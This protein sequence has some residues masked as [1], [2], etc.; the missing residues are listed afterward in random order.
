MTE[1]RTA[2]AAASGILGDRVA[3]LVLAICHETGNWVSAIRMNA[4][5][6]DHEQA[7]IELTRAALEIDDLSARIGAILALVRPLIAEELP[8]GRTLPANVMLG[9]RE[10]VGTRR[11]R[12]GGLSVACDDELPLVAC[13]PE[14]LH[15]LI[16]T[17]TH[18]A[19]EAAGPQGSVAV[20]AR[21]DPDDGT[22][23]V[24]IEDNG[25]E[26]PGLAD[27]RGAPLRGRVLACALAS[28]LLG[29]CGG[30]VDVARVGSRTRVALVVPRA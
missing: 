3:Q 26:E 11:P 2:A 23:V 14:M 30:R 29:R 16:V 8:E 21:S 17:L 12:G 15:E 5:L 27:W 19:L 9:V 20:R 13:Q 22:L 18:Y 28:G 7:P 1:Q 24:A 25:P 10:S 6:L 4:H